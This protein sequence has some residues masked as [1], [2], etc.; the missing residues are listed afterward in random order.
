MLTSPSLTDS[1]PP[2]NPVRP[3]TAPSDVDAPT[4]QPPDTPQLGPTNPKI[5][6]KGVK[7]STK[8]GKNQ[9]TRDNTQTPLEADA[10]AVNGERRSRR[11]AGEEASPPRNARSGDNTDVAGG[12]KEPPEVD[13]PAQPANVQHK[14]HGRG[15]GS[16]QVN[17]HKISMNE[18][19]R[20]VNTMLNTVSSAQIEIA[21]NKSYQLAVHSALHG[22]TKEE[23]S[24]EAENTAEKENQQQSGGTA[25]NSSGSTRGFPM[26]LEDFEKLPHT[27]MA[28]LLSTQLIL[29]Q[30]EFGKPGEK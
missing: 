27:E 2:E 3:S 9:W 14:G 23:E 30:Q 4:S 12:G 5:Q 28:N 26:P 29:W 21:G 6:K 19:R 1:E 15:K 18:I 13:D 8:R 25:S 16:K 24:L 17:I 20:R 10:P 11:A 7:T 22:T